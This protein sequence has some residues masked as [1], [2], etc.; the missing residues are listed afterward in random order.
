MRCHLADPEIMHSKMTLLLA[1]GSIGI[2]ILGIRTLQTTVINTTQ[3]CYRFDAGGLIG[4]LCL[5][6]DMLVYME[7]SK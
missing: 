3:R 1:V 2:A 7:I 6:H 5:C 4:P